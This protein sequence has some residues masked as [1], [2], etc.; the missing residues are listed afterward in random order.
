[1]IM[2]R[3]VGLL[4]L[5]ICLVRLCGAQESTRSRLY[6]V[7][8][9]HVYGGQLLIHREAMQGMKVNKPYL[10]QDLRV[11]LQ[12]TG[13]AYWQEAYRY[14]IYGIGFYSGYFNNPIIGNPM[15]LYG[16]IDIPFIRKGKVSWNTSWGFGLSFHINE[17]NAE[18]NPENVAISTETNAYIDF[19][20][21]YKYQ[22]T[23]RLN[24]GLGVQ[25]QHLSN[26]AFKHPN[27]GLNLLTGSLTASYTFK[28]EELR[29]TRKT[30]EAYDKY[31]F[32]LM[33]A[34]GMSALA[35]DDPKQYYSSTLSATA[36][37]RMSEKRTLGL[38]VDVFYNS[39]LLGIEDTPEPICTKN[40]MSY[41]GIVSSEMILQDFRMLI[42]F[43]VY[44]WRPMAYDKPFYERVAFRYYCFD[45][46]L[47]A[48]ISVKAHG[49][50]SQCIEWGLGVNF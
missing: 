19:I 22:I 18:T 47:F 26:G 5:L 36:H 42:Q 40:L 3:F 1:M 20:T 34:G 41:A 37:R 31:A 27:L 30:P 49:F 32:A 12:S 46:F 10:G 44:V 24:M 4:C 38:G 23:P 8:S 7:I 50:K 11:G 15:A 45:D 17:Y 2:K 48:N 16:F 6:P 25:F 33:Y 14:P 29:F 39:C 35:K 13:T 9:Y 28:G 21:S 43:G